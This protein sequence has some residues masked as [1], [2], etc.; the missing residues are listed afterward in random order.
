MNEEESETKMQKH[1][2]EQQ[3]HSRQQQ[4]QQQQQQQP[5]PERLLR[6]RHQ[7]RKHYGYGGGTSFVGGSPP[8]RS[9]KKVLL[10]PR[11]TTASASLSN[12][13]SSSQPW[14]VPPSVPIMMMTMTMNP[15]PRRRIPVPFSSFHSSTIPTTPR[16]PSSFISRNVHTRAEVSTVTSSSTSLQGDQHRQITSPPNPLRMATTKTANH[17][18]PKPM[19][20]PN[21]ASSL[22]LFGGG[23]LCFEQVGNP[24][25]NV[26]R[27]KLPPSLVEGQYLSNII[28]HAEQ[29]ANTLKGGWKTDLYS[30]T[31]CDMACKDIPGMSARIQ[32]IFQYICHSIQILYGC[33]KVM[34]DK[35]QPHILKYSADTGHTGGTVKCLEYLCVI[36]CFHLSSGLDTSC[37]SHPTA[38]LL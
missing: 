1:H 23:G 14:L 35:N 17:T 31:K 10:Y 4:Q 21:P 11:G 12:G 6:R 36:C 32:P 15:Q 13:S 18:L 25:L 30:L 16:P 26:F 22:S 9:S 24:Q 34:V 37:L 19:L 20:L 29:H 38:V 28:H 8:K 33:R 3:K 2:L 7:Q 5:S 27:V